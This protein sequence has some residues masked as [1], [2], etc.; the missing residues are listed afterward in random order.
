MEIMVVDDEPILRWM[1]SE[2]LQDAGH[3]V[4]DAPTADEALAMLRA[5]VRHALWSRTYTCPVN[6]TASNL[7]S[8]LSSVAAHRRGVGLWKAEAIPR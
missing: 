7:P 3:S 4:T 1:F 5:A 2:I 8:D 6:S